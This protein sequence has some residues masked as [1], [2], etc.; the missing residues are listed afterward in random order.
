MFRGSFYTK[1][2]YH[3]KLKFCPAWWAAWKNCVFHAPSRAVH[4]GAGLGPVLFRLFSFAASLLVPSGPCA[5]T[6]V[7]K[8]GICGGSSEYQFTFEDL[9]ES[10]ESLPLMKALRDL[11]NKLFFLLVFKALSEIS[12]QYLLSVCLSSTSVKEFFFYSCHSFQMTSL[13]SYI[14]IFFVL[15]F[16]MLLFSVLLRSLGFGVHRAECEPQTLG[17]GKAQMIV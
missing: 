5:Y 14:S 8:R 17:L 12:P 6:R 15:L 13:F 16:L 7:C 4:S 11:F 1:K 3:L 9:I 10:D 2:P